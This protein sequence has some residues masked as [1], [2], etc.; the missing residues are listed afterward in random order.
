MSKNKRH[1]RRVD[2]VGVVPKYLRSNSF[3]RIRRVDGY[4]RLMEHVYYDYTDATRRRLLLVIAERPDIYFT[5]Y[6]RG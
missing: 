2:R 6:E 1:R 5:Y 3:I 4:D